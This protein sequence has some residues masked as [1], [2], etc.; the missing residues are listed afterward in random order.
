[1]RA[2][3]LAFVALAAVLTACGIGVV[4]VATTD[5]PETGNDSGRDSTTDTSVAEAAAFA[6]GGIDAPNTIVD[7][8]ADADED[9]ETNPDVDAGGP[10]KDAGTDA[11]ASGP[12]T[13]CKK[14]TPKADVCA[15]FDEGPDVNAGWD[16][17]PLDAGASVSMSTTVFESGT[18]SLHAQ[19]TQGKPAVLRKTLM[20]TTS[21]TVDYDVY[22]PALPASGDVS[23]VLASPPTFPGFDVY[24][25]V[26]NN[27]TYFQEYGDQYS[28]ML[29]AAP[30]NT[31]QHVSLAFTLT[32]NATTATAKF[33]ATTYWNNQQL[34]HTWPTP[35]QLTVEVGLANLY[36]VTAS[37][38]YL[39][40]IVI[41]AQ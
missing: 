12:D 41:R 26:S 7:A 29:A 15:D 1:M 27:T 36:Q 6:D 38:A 13:F 25:F 11:D 21:L 24:F 9:A 28:S 8:N 17:E 4:G 31:W 39:D 14:L 18:R 3:R 34:S 30:T 23:T 37:E 10:V 22:Y 32:S 5:S 2:R 20:V 40:N 19:S 35:V 16:P 33:G